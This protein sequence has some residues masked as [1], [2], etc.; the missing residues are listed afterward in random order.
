MVRLPATGMT[1]ARPWSCGKREPP[2][3]AISRNRTCRRCSWSAP[4]LKRLRSN[5]PELPRQRRQRLRS[6]MIFRLKSGH[7]GTRELADFRSGGGSYDYRSYRNLATGCGDLIY[8]LRRWEKG[9]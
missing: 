2:I 9:G 8:Q 4:I 1:A 3:T 6:V 5:F 7:T